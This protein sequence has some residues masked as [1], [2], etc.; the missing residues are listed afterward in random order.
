LISF[1][2]G[3]KI[4]DYFKKYSVFDLMINWRDRDLEKL[5]VFFS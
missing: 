1:S 4:Y 3:L 5:S 2:V